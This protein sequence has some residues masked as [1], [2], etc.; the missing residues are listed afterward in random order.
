MSTLKNPFTPFDPAL[1]AAF[2]ANIQAALAE[3]V[4]R[5]MSGSRRA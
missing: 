2:E 4:G 3:D 5:N 1:V